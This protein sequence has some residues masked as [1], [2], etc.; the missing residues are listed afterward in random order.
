VV[1]VGTPLAAF[2]WRGQRDEA[3]Q[4]ERHAASA[5]QEAREKLRQSYLSQAELMR[6]SKQA[7][8]RFRGLELLHEAWSIR[9]SPAVRN[10]AIACLGLPDLK[11][12]RQWPFPT[13]MTD[14]AAFDATLERY[15]YKEDRRSQISVRS[16][17][18]DRELLALH[19]PS[20]F[21]WVFEMKFS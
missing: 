16:A 12:S 18:D 8:Q 1:A 3:R 19:G 13:P 21:A 11:V 7:G 6:S 15:A 17:A 10:S 5:E 4:N 14:G 2:M 20:D 9:Q